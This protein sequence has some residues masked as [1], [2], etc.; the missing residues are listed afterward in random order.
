MVTRRPSRVY[1]P[2][3]RGVPAGQAAVALWVVLHPELGAAADL[4]EDPGR[5]PGGEHAIGDDHSRR[6]RG[7]ARDQ[8]AGADDDAVEHRGSVTHQRFRADDRAV[9]DA[10]VADGRPLSYL[11]DRIGTSVQHRP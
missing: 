3:T 1:G 2:Y 4:P 11:G 9:D 6:D 8:P 7:A 5:D 10:Q